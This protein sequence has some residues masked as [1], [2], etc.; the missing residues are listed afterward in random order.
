[1]E[2]ERIEQDGSDLREVISGLAGEIGTLVRQEADLVRCELEEKAETAK[3]G[4]VRVGMGG[5]FAFVG[6]F[7]LAAAAVL[8]GT[9]LLVQWMSPLAAACVSA[10]VVGVILAA[11]GAGLLKSGGERL[12]PGRL[13]PRRSLE[14]IKEDARWARKQF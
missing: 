13:L 7:A 14:S 2:E 6:A 8:G 4:A 12:R 11:V 10:A 1:V 5:A 9:L 3:Q